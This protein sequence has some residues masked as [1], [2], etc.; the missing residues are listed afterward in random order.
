MFIRQCLSEMEM[1]H[2]QYYN[3]CTR[4]QG[5]KDILFVEGWKCFDIYFKVENVWKC[6]KIENVQSWKCSRLK[7]FWHI[8]KFSASSVACLCNAMMRVRTK[9]A[10]SKR[11]SLHRIR[12]LKWHV[13]KLRNLCFILSFLATV[14]MWGAKCNFRVEN[15]KISTLCKFHKE[16]AS[17]GIWYLDKKCENVSDSTFPFP[18][19]KF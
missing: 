17:L 12:H 10:L 6:F 19:P 5:T 8:S 16:N 2:L 11:S 9:N 14:S 13:S 15:L 4:H 3:N 1:Q 18:F 7:M